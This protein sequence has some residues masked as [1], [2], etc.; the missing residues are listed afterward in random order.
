MC[1]LKH[2]NIVPFLGIAN[3]PEHDGQVPICLITPWMDNGDMAH[4]LEN[5]P[6]ADRL[7]L[8]AGVADALAYMHNLAPIVVHGDVKVANILIDGEGNAVLADFGLS[9]RID[10]NLLKRNPSS[11]AHGTLEYVSPERIRPE[12]FGMDMFRAWAPPTDVFSFGMLIY[13]SFLC[14]PPFCVTVC[15]QRVRSPGLKVLQLIGRGIRPAVPL[16]WEDMPLMDAVATLM[17]A[18]WSHDPGNRPPMDVVRRRLL[19]LSEI[20]RHNPIP[21]ASGCGGPRP[22]G[23]EVG[24]SSKPSQL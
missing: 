20:Q 2:R 12:D 8:L 5:H 11:A 3:I 21:L 18:C 24:P 9:R 17:Q 16:A 22:G 23:A 6:D 15:N 14:E 13:E 7:P 1:E 19:E 4:Y 10:E